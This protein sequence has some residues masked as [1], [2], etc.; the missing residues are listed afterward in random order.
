M[1]YRKRLNPSSKFISA[2]LKTLSCGT[3]SALMLMPGAHA[4]GLGEITIL[5]FLEQPLRAE[6]ELNA[7]SKHEETQLV[8]KLAS[9]EIPISTSISTSIQL[10]YHCNF[11]LISAAH[12]NLS[13]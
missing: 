2:G 3:L 11:R 12:A 8:V 7:V 13:G 5:S 10:Y 6:I 1:P 4:A 9:S